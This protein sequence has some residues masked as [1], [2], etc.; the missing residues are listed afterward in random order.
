MKTKVIQQFTAIIALEKKHDKGNS[1]YT[2]EFD[3]KGLFTST[4]YI[5]QTIEEKFGE[6]Y[7]VEFVE[8]LKQAIE[9]Y[10]VKQE[11]FCAA[12]MERELVNAIEKTES[13]EDIQFNEFALYIFSYYLNEKIKDGSYIYKREY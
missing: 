7:N 9:T 3:D 12:Y 2:V 11:D 8:D 4:E 1:Y 6:V 10:T 13:F 5:L